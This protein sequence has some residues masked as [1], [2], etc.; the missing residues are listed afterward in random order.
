[1]YQASVVAPRADI[2]LLEIGVLAISLTVCMWAFESG[3]ILGL[4]G[5]VVGALV[6]PNRGRG[7][8][9]SFEGAFAGLWAGLMLGGMVGGGLARLQ[10]AIA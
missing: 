2:S 10:S 1:M 9:V 6:G 7:H 5:L 3:G 4:A 8:P